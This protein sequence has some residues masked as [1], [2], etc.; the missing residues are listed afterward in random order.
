M[1]L[2]TEEY[3]FCFTHFDSSQKWGRRVQ[4]KDTPWDAAD[5]A[6]QQL[7][8]AS[9][10]IPLK[11]ARGASVSLLTAGWIYT[12]NNAVLESVFAQLPHKLSMGKSHN[13]CI[14]DF[15]NLAFSFW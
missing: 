15:M 13:A 4:N 12:A 11:L 5:V 6:L 3:D 10:G 7:R 2:F 8:V 9:A 1:H 14:S